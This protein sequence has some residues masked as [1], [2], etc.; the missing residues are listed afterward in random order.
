[1]AIILKEIRFT[2]S[3]FDSLLSS[4]SDNLEGFSL[5]LELELELLDSLCDYSSYTL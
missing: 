5:S 3:S 1:V 4:I 2:P